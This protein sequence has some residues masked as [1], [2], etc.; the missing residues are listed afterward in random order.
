MRLQGFATAPFQAA[1]NTP[2]LH[3]AFDHLTEAGARHL[4]DRGAALMGIDSVNI[5]D[6][7]GA[8]RPAHSVLLAAG[9]RSS[10]T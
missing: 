8:A 10:S 3:E 2:E 6:T 1:A 9:S 4:V 7:V 5:D